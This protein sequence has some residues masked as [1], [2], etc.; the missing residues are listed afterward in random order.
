[1]TSNTRDLRALHYG[2]RAPEQPSKTPDEPMTAAPFA[3]LDRHEVPEEVEDPEPVEQPRNPFDDDEPSVASW[4]KPG[5]DSAVRAKLRGPVMI[6]M[7]H[8]TPGPGPSTERSV[9]LLSPAWSGSEEQIARYVARGYRV[10]TPSERLGRPRN[11]YSHP[12][13]GD[14][15]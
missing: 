14:S 13:R 8:T 10:L 3:P 15:K 2:L 11:P 5:L 9:F 6:K 7:V 4:L 12:Q 1:M